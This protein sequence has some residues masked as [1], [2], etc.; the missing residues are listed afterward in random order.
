[1]D[2]LQPFSQASSA[3]L[4]LRTVFLLRV[5]FLAEPGLDSSI[6]L[7]GAKAHFPVGLD[8]TFVVLKVFLTILSLGLALPL[9]PSEN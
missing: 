7:P 4:Y 5:L 2:N 8:E 1:M 3:P 9:S 6:F